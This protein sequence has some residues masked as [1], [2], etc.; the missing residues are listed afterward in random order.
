M[1]VPALVAAVF[2]LFELELQPAVVA[3]M[4]ATAART[5]DDATELRR[6]LTLS[7]LCRV[8]ELLISDSV[9]Q[10]HETVK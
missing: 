3:P 10:I 1:A 9:S 4:R 6:V 8:D 5:T 2:A 7:P